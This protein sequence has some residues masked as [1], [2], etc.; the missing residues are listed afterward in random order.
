[1]KQPFK[2]LSL[3]TMLSIMAI[4]L[5]LAID[6]LVKQQRIAHEM[7][8]KMEQGAQKTY[9]FS[10]QDISWIKEGKELLIKGKMFDVKHFKI[11][12]NSIEVTGIFD[13][14]EDALQHQFSLLIN[15]VKNTPTP[16]QT[17]LIKSIFAP[18]FF[19]SNTI[20]PPGIYTVAIQKTSFNYKE[21][22]TKKNYPVNIPPP[23]VFS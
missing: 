9:Q 3:I 14:E 7:F 12:G 5:C 19:E 22:S 8:E 21:S 16:L 17:I 13:E 18:V 10:I 23:K 1:M 6:F 2:F 20:E 11:K 4:P 15:P